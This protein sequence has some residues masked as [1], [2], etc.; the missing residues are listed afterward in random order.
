MRDVTFLAREVRQHCP[1]TVLFTLNSDLLYA[2]PDVNGA[3]RGM[4][5]ITP[6]PLFN[7][8]QLWT[9]AYGGA[10][11]VF[12]SRIRPRKASTT[13]PW[14]FFIRMESWSI[15]EGRWRS[16]RTH[17]TEPHK[18]S[19]W[20]TAIGNEKTLPVAL[21]GWKDEEQLHLFTGCSERGK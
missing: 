19:L 15:M 2:Y 1:A 14:L 21:L 9:Y 12:S 18:P 8:E 10:N 3:T 5:V 20:V 13:R 6:Y 17:A 11:R 16:P 7:L 4:I